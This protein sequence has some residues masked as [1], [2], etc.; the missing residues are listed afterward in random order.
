[1]TDSL[2]SQQLQPSADLG[3]HAQ[4]KQS[5]IQKHQI[6]VIAEQ[7]FNATS[8]ERKTQILARLARRIKGPALLNGASRDRLLTSYFMQQARN[9]LM[10]HA[11]PPA[12]ESPET[13]ESKDYCV[14]QDLVSRFVS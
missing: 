4:L 5:D 6:I 9:M 7:V 12:S 10:N 11:Q 8:D 3:S 13:S 14:I 2:Y 1:M